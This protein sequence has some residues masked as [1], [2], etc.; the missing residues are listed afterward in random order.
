[1]TDS[2]KTDTFPHKST[3]LQYVQVPKV[4]PIKIQ[5]IKRKLVPFIMNNINWTDKG[6]WIEP[7][8]GS[9]IVMFNA[10][11]QTAAA[12][13]HN[14]HII[15]MYTGIQNG[16][17]T[18]ASVRDFLVREGGRLS[19]YGEQYYY[20]VRDRFNS[21]QDPLDFLFLNRSCFNG[22]IRFNSKGRFNTPFCRKPNRFSK[23]YVTKI[24]NQVRW[25]DDLL[26]NGGKQW[27]F[28]ALDWKDALTDIKDDD[29]LYLDPP[30]AGRHTN[31]YDVWDE[32]DLS[33][34]AN[35]LKSGNVKFA[36]SIW[37][38]NKYR[39]NDDVE[40]YFSGF[41]IRK[42]EHFYHLGSTES[43]RNSMT[44]ALIMRL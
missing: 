27:T 30:Y 43:L 17:I 11:P 35:F 42:H 40:K 21:V 19:E 34:L 2:V 22:L 33:D 31:Y 37:Y 39:R 15:E 9:G 36:L 7:F 44:E 14:P 32:S 10:S 26:A 1:M 28:E 29:F 3:M 24:V 4:P 23:A 6:R 25:L 12:S 16:Q 41:T 18:P 38:E 5:G 13:D 20:E 8:L